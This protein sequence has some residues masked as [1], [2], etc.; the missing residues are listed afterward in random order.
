MAAGMKVSIVAGGTGGHIF[1]AMTLEKELK[2]N[3]AVKKVTLLATTTSLSKKVLKGREKDVV[4]IP[5]QGFVGKSF[6]KK[7]LAIAYALRGLF[8]SFML[9]KKERPD[10]ACGFGGYGTLTYLLVCYMKRIPFILHEQNI[11]PGR[12]TRFLS[13]FAKEI[14]ISFP[15]SEKFL[16]PKKTFFIG[17]IS[18]E[19]FVDYHRT[20]NK[21]GYEPENKKTIVIVGGSQ[22][23]HFL[24]R[25]LP[26]A[27]LKI[28]NDFPKLSIVHI[29]GE[30]G[31]RSVEDMYN[32]LYGISKDIIASEAIQHQLPGVVSEWQSN[33]HRVN[34]IDF[35][36]NM[37]SLLKDA[38]LVIS[39]AGAT[40]LSEI[41]LCG[42]PCILIPF[43]ASADN[44]QYHNALWF[45]E[46]AAALL[47]E[48]INFTD[49]FFY[50]SMR[51]LL[52]SPY[53]LKKM[54]SALLS[55]ACPHAAKLA[56]V[57]VIAMKHQQFGVSSKQSNSQK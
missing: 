44:H 12:V 46:R 29:T 4:S 3:K 16:P 40:I 5:S 47:I 21:S 55:L 33:S 42:T 15:D 8:S 34:V 48:E 9:L 23:S 49:N 6:Y 50:Q 35:S 26:G 36:V 17:N 2:K 31:K 28:L 39:R 20:L 38:R 10:L 53:K 7:I 43:A 27:L 30:K 22:G 14:L 11:I 19:D 13:K 32:S 25:N 54:S 57:E 41:S 56:A 18:R 45:R 1:P 52:N 37:L 51:D 24:N